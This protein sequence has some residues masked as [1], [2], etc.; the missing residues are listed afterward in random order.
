MTLSKKEDDIGLKEVG[1]NSKGTWDHSKQRNRINFTF[2]KRSR[3]LD[4]LIIKIYIK[5]MRHS[6]FRIRWCKTF[7]RFK[8]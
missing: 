6:W 8:K 2:E 3:K 4:Y 1:I 7:C 5:A